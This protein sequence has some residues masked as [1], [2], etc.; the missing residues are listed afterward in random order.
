MT[1]RHFG[2][3][4][5]L[6]LHVLRASRFTL[7][8]RDWLKKLRVDW[9]SIKSVSKSQVNDVDKLLFKFSDVFE[10]QG[11]LK[12][13]PAKLELIEGATPKRAKPYRVPIALQSAVDKELDRLVSAGVL[14]PVQHSDWATSLLFVPKS[15]GSIRPCGDFKSTV[16]PLLK[17][18]APPQIN[19]DDILSNLAG[20][21]FF[22]NLDFTQAYNQMAIDEPSRELLTLVTHKGLFQYTRLP[23]GI[24]TAPSLWQRAVKKVL[25]GIDGIHIYYDNVLVAG[26]SIEEHNHRLGLVLQKLEDNGLKRKRSKCSF[27]RT[28]VTYLGHVINEHGTKPIPAKIESILST[29]TPRDKFKVRSYLGLLNFYRRYLPNLASV[30]AP[31][32]ALMKN[33]AKFD[34]SSE[35]NTAFIQSKELLQSS[36][37]LVHFDPN[38]PVK[39]TCDASRV[40]M[41]AVLSHTVNGVE[42]PVQF[43]SQKLT[44]AQ[45]LYPQIEREGL[46]IIFGLDRFR[47]YL[48]GRKFVLVADNQALSKIFAPSRGLPVMTAERIQRWALKLSSFDYTVEWKRSADNQADFLSRYPS[49]ESDVVHHEEEQAF[50]FKVDDLKLL[51]TSSQI[52][53]ATSRDVLLSKVSRLINEGWPTLFC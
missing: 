35:A 53:R 4:R 49:S 29:E 24:K 42:R 52:A 40:G 8:G 27:L 28:E 1:V 10:G 6:W 12:G 51:I 5:R 39:L 9:Q 14:V 13:T 37:L 20:N 16:N 50:V 23:Y 31:L 44:S 43:A 2:Q 38:L 15:D 26:H 11:L 45:T 48:Y 30:V 25:S 7:L 3:T 32:S 47:H 34:W 33:H 21:K 18:V 36:N 19:M 41:A 46:A 17:N 22:S